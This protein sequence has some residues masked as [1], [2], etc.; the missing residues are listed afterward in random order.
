MTPH[1]T[2]PLAGLC[3]AVALALGACASQPLPT[4]QLALAEQAIRDAE[5][6]GAVELAPVEMRNA[7]EK[8]GAAQRAAG[9]REVDTTTRLA[10]QAQVDAQLAEATARAA[11]S[12][13]AVEQLE[14]SL[15][16]L[17]RETQRSGQP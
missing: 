11:K 12:T 16:A 9:E 13:R 15:R 6:A 8:L 3:A 5:R 4:D 7:R 14:D 17:Q 10:E 1:I 2:R